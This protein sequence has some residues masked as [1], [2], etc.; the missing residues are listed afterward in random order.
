MVFTFY[1]FILFLQI[2]EQNLIEPYDKQ[3]TETQARIRWAIE[4][5]TLNN[6]VSPEKVTPFK[7]KIYF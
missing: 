5:K 4:K 7:K 6:I 2:S 1:S 3:S